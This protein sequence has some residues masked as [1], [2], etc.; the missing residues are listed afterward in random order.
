MSEALALSFDSADGFSHMQ[1]VSKMFS[2]SALVPEAFRGEAGLPNCVIALEMAMRMKAS[3][4]AVMQNIYIV[5]GKPSWSSTF[6]I[7][8]INTCGKFRPLRFDVAGAGDD[9]T[10]IAWTTEVDV[11][12]PVEVRTL[13]QAREQS[14]PVLESPPVSVKM[15]K[16]EGWY[17]KNGSKWKTMP[18]LMLRYRAATLFGRLYAPELLMGMRTMEEAIDIESTVVA[19]KEQP[20]FERKA[21]E[22][23]K[24]EPTGTPHERL[25]FLCKNCQIS[26]SEILTIL[27]RKGLTAAEELMAVADTALID[28]EKNWD[29]FVTQV[30]IDRKGA[31]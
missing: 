25:L 13:Q 12:I 17:G 28:V 31:K 10:C 9:R 19:P 16:D 24:T 30:K 1:R 3:P 21:K 5:H 11:T 14:L 6:I 2:S 22:E 23:S 27:Q 26:E 18:E 15:A 29:A 4:L 20:T 8:C 7:A